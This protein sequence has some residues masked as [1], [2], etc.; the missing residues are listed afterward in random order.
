M[1][2]FISR[3]LRPDSALHHLTSKGHSITGISGIEFSAL[4]FES[5][6]DTDWLFFYSQHGIHFF[7]SGLNSEQRQQVEKKKKGVMGKASASMLNQITGQK[8]DF[9]AGINLESDAQ[10]F[11]SITNNQSVLFI[12]AS[13]SKKRF[14]NPLNQNHFILKVYDNVIKTDLILP[15]ADVY[16]FTS[17]LNVQAFLSKNKVYPT[18]RLMAIGEPTAKTLFEVT[19]RNDIIIAHSSDEEGVLS[20]LTQ[21]LKL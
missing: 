6:Q 13:H 9:I 12:E 17:P 3:Q 15:L 8:P 19:K 20:T 4:P 1:N 18:S 2:L 5:F 11:N 21:Y 14:Q 10:T 16:I 7:Y